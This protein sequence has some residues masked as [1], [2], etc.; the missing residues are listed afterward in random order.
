MNSL[1]L[2]NIGNKDRIIYLFLRRDKQLIIRKDKSFYPYFFEPDEKG[3][4]LS[5][6]GIP[7]KK[8]ITNTPKEIPIIRSED[9]YSS[10]IKYTK[11]YTIDKIDNIEK[12]NYRFAFLDI[13]IQS[14]DE[15]PDPKTAKYPISSITYWDNYNKEYRNWFLL[16]YATEGEMLDSFVKYINANTP[17]IILGWNV[18]KFDYPYLNN[19][20]KN[21][22]RKISPVHL[23]RKGEGKDIFY[24][25]GISIVDYLAMFKKVFIREKIFNLDYI[26]EKYLGKGKQYKNKDLDFGSLDKE[27]KLR[28]I[29][30]VKIL[31]A[32]EEKYNL[33]PYY[34]EIRR[35]AL[36]QWEDLIFNSRIIEMLLFKEAKKKNIILPNKKENKEEK[37]KGA[38]RNSLALGDYYGVG[39]ADLT[40][41]YPSMI[42]NFCLDSNNISNKKEKNTVEINGICFRQDPEALVPLV[43]RKILTLKNELKPKAKKDHSLK[44]LYMA[45]KGITNSGYGVLA[46]EHFRLFDPR[47]SGAT[48]YLVR[49]VLNYVMHKIKKDGYKILYYDTD[50]C[51]YDTKEDITDKLNAYI[52]EWARKMGKDNIDLEFDYEGYFDKIFFLGRCHY[53]AYMH[54]E[55]EPEIKGVEIKRSSSSKYEA[56]FQKELFEKIFDKETIDSIVDWI[57]KEMIR[58]KT[59]DPVEYGFPFRKNEKKY[60]YEPIFIRAYNNT[61]YLYGKSLNTTKPMY[62]TYIQERSFNNNKA[63]DVIA[64]SEDFKDFLSKEK[65]DWNKMID[66]NIVS[67][68]EAIF[69]AKGWNINLIKPQVILF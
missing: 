44:N 3:N 45:V 37:I 28:N 60:V 66:R 18:V 17:D 19:R 22:A 29:D 33:F 4:Y 53:Y 24:P 25:I 51:F 16:D 35:L 58:I 64:F 68:A 38:I 39:T 30:D 31:V 54:G 41:A 52:Q 67:K 20:I 8:V 47:V 21:F 43:L 63:I 6:D 42:I 5:Y 59:L 56:Y 10:D 14:R 12:T 62:Y 50:S 27:I 2:V 9:S 57:K 65:I 13:E 15:F 7:L 36:C 11:V 55:K 34:D 32:L 49:N 23:V 69:E 1:P 40:S 46:N 26:G 48:T 61:K